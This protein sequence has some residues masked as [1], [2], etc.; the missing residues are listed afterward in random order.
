MRN[1]AADDDTA[2]FHAHLGEL[3]AIEATRELAEIPAISEAFIHKCLADMRA[4]GLIESA[5]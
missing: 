5:G 2:C 1:D 3:A 4:L